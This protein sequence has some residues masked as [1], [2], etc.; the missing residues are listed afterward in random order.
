MEKFAS[1][2][3]TEPEEY[4]SKKEDEKLMEEI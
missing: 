3:K 2:P 1:Y 4:L